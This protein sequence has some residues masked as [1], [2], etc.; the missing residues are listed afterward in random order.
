LT[1]RREVLG[2]LGAALAVAWGCNRRSAASDDPALPLGPMETRLA[3]YNWSDYIAP[4]TVRGFERETGVRVTYDTY[5]SNEEM[6]AKL[7]AGASGYDLAVP[8]SYMLPA[9]RASNLL[10]PLHGQYIQGRGAIAPLFRHPPFDPAE[11]FTV[12]WQW[13]ITGIA[14]RRDLVRTAPSDWGIFFDQRWRGRM[15]MMDDGREV[16]GAMLKHRGRPLNDAEAASLAT[17]KADAIRAKANLRAY[18]SA[19]VKADLIAGDVWIAQLWNGDAAQAALDQP[20]IS[21]VLPGDGSAIW[22]DSFVLLRDAPHPRAAHAFLEYILRPDVAAKVADA[23]GYGSP[24]APALARQRHPVPYPSPEER[25]RLEYFEDL[26]A[27]TELW[28]RAW[29]EIKSA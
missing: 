24:N 17:A 21:F 19:P 23:T 25:S 12:P 7:Q 8:S 11:Q 16:L 28:D 9:M 15:T 22:T 1:T 5:E 27:A 29:T 18:K 3:I 6:F 10:A 2:G 4:D 20:A 14:W 13:G 26:G